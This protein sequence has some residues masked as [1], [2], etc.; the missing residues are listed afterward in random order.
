MYSVPWN[1]KEDL[2]GKELVHLDSQQPTAIADR[3][4]APRVLD[5]RLTAFLHQIS[6]TKGDKIGDKS[7]IPL[8]GYTDYN[9]E[10]IRYAKDLSSFNFGSTILVIKMTTSE[11]H[12]RHAKLIGYL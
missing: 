9:K 11:L 3:T 6:Q 4:I 2:E 10:G 5:A 8:S 12:L 1:G 7:F